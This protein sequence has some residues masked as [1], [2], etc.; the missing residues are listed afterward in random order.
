MFKRFFLALSLF[1]AMAF[2][3]QAQTWK[4][5]SVFPADSTMN[6]GIHGIAVD[7]DG[8][9]WIQAYYAYS[10]DSIQVPGYDA[11][12]GALKTVTAK[13]RAIYVYNPDG[14]QAS[15]SP[16]L[17]NKVGGVVKDTIGGETTYKSIKN[18]LDTNTTITVPAWGGNTGRGL[19]LDA[20]GNVVAGCWDYLF[21][22]DYKTGEGLTNRI[23]CNLGGTTKPGVDAAG[24]YYSRSLLSR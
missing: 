18:P 16:I 10:R 21:K 23:V 4:M 14:T 11:A 3:Y 20:S 22:F 1:I 12:T 15:F 24:N 2:N 7:P 5:D 19:T 13:V 17:F 8:K 9:V 6:N